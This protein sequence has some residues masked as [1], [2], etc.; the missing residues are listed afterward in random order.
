MHWDQMWLVVLYSADWLTLSNDQGNMEFPVVG[1]GLPRRLIQE[2]GT[3]RSWYLG[4][5]SRD[6][7][8]DLRSRGQIS[9]ARCREEHPRWSMLD[10]LRRLANN[11]PTAELLASVWSAHHP[12]A[13]SWGLR[14]WAL[15]LDMS[16]RWP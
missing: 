3:R 15:S 5:P 14:L 6:T 2:A 10:D 13:E 7:F 12:S 9:Q 11:Q 16:T 1:F 4:S 8:Q